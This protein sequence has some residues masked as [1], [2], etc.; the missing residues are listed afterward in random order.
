MGETQHTLFPLDFNR[1]IVLEDR[2]ER[3]TGDAGVLA[4]RQIDHRRPA[5]LPPNRPPPAATRPRHCKRLNCYVPSSLRRCLTRATS[6][7]ATL[8]TQI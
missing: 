1:S 8:L 6:A 3:L 4:L 5:N 2:P 7:R